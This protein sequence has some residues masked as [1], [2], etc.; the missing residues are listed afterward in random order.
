LA[1]FA[2]REKRVKDAM[3]HFAESVKASFE[4]AFALLA[5]LLFIG[6]ATADRQAQGLRFLRR[7][8]ASGHDTLE[9]RPL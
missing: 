2:L 1:C 4:P 8:V 3:S 9:E 6:K 7:G 5:S